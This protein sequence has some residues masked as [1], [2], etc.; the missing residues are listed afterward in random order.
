MDHFDGAQ[1]PFPAFDNGSPGSPDHDDLADGIDMM[2]DL[3]QSIMP[4]GAD[5]M[6]GAEL[7][8]PPP[9]RRAI[10]GPNAPRPSGYAVVGG[11]AAEYEAMGDEEM[12]DLEYSTFTDYLQ[13]ANYTPERQRLEKD[14]RRTV[15]NRLSARKTLAKKRESKQG[16]ELANRALLG[17]NARLKQM[18]AKMRLEME[19]ERRR[20]NLQMAHLQ[21]LQLNGGLSDMGAAHEA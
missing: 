2:F 6:G 7:P 1:P 14:R 4:N 19:E 8:A 5:D 11:A 13:R 9:P 20:T 18:I 10:P 16:L 12:A 3:F 17:E 15:K 21:A